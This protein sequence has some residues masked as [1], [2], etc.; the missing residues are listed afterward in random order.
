MNP[1]ESST[2]FPHNDNLLNLTG[3]EIGKERGELT[4]CPRK[5]LSLKPVDWLL[6]ARAAWSPR[7]ERLEYSN[8]PLE[9]SLIFSNVTPTL[10]TDRAIPIPCL[11]T[12]EKFVR[13]NAEYPINF[14]KDSM[15]K[16][17]KR[18]N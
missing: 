16:G 8:N 17:Q 15:V 7:L 18:S 10:N 4:F 5:S 3:I 9:C 11:L 12:V 14:G 6:K 2:N 13:P 1:Q